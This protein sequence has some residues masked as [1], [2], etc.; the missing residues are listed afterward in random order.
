MKI[1]SIAGLLLAGQAGLGAALDLRPGISSATSVVNSLHHGFTTGDFTGLPRLPTGCGDAMVNDGGLCYTPCND[2]DTGV[3]PVCWGNCPEGFT[4]AGAL[5]TDWRLGSS[6][7]LV[8]V[9][10]ASYGRGAGVIPATFGPASCTDPDFQNFEA[11]LCHYSGGSDDEEE[12]AHRRLQA[13][14]RGP[15]G[16]C[17]FKLAPKP[18]NVDEQRWQ[19]RIRAILRF[20]ELRKNLIDAG[21]STDEIREIGARFVP[22]LFQ[23]V[24]KTHASLTARGLSGTALEDEMFKEFPCWA[25]WNWVYTGKVTRAEVKAVRAKVKDVQQG[26]DTWIPHT[27]APTYAPSVWEEKCNVVCPAFSTRKADV[28]CLD[29]LDK[30][31]CKAGYAMNNEHGRCERVKEVARGSLRGGRRDI[32][33]VQEDL[34]RQMQ[35]LQKAMMDQ[36]K[37]GFKLFG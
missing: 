16:L 1:F 21:I 9:A 22:T 14:N 7:H 34:Q 31:E 37:K 15:N 2:G 28:H 5:C 23:S 6:T 32:D 25:S 12:N 27:P 13:S 10:K 18:D 4:D 24:K 19:Q 17:R 30:C 33:E 8:T 11:G 20:K 35:D 29:S 26:Y 3:G 36:A